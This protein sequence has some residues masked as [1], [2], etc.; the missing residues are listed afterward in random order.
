MNSLRK[1]IITLFM[2]LFVVTVS[3]AQT[4]ESWKTLEKPLNFYGY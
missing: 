3:F 4:P 1:N 2:A